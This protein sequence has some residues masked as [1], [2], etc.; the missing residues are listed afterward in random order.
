MSPALGFALAFAA[1]VLL[2][3]V[4]LAGLWVTVRHVQVS[5]HPLVWL[6]TSLVARIA[7]VLVA[8]YCIL[9]DGHWQR[10]VVALAGFLVARTIAI[11]RIR[12][13]R[14]APLGKKRTPA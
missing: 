11:R 4:Y 6:A 10:L 5:Q 3:I 2:A 13:R 7:L 1:G 14:T 9:G 12:P 8:F